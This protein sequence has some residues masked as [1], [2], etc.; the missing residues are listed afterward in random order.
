MIFV[1]YSWKDRSA[2]KIVEASLNRIGLAY[3]I[4]CNEL[5]LHHCLKTQIAEAI[6]MS[7]QV[8]HITSESSNVSPW[9]C[10]EL[11]TASNMAKTIVELDVRGLKLKPNNAFHVDNLLAALLYCQ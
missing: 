7:L 6:S 2:V 1:S 4:D 10:F 3:W 5:D 11:A 8:L 9:V